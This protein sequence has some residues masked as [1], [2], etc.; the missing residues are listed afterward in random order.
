MNNETMVYLKPNVVLEPLFDRWYAWT[1]LISPAT[2]AMNVKGRH[3]KIMNSYI[4][5]PEAHEKAVKNPKMLG[6]PFMDFKRNRS[7]DV[8]KLMED[9][10]HN[11]KDSLAFADAIQELEKLL[12]AKGK[13][14]SLEPLYQEI[15]E[16]LQGYVELYYDLNNNPTYRI[17]EALLYHAD[18][19]REEAQSIALWLTENDDRPFVLSTPRL[20]DENVLHLNIPF[21]AASIDALFKMRQQAQKL[22]VIKKT[23]GLSADQEALFETFFTEHAPA[24]YKKYEGDKIR[25]RYFGHACVLIETKDVSILVDPLVSYYGF[26]SE[27]AH[28]TDAD[29]PDQ[30]D[31]VL[32]THNH[33]DHIIFETLLP[34]RHRIKNVIVPRTSSG[35]LEDPNLKLMFNHIGFKNVYELT[36]MVDPIYFA[37]C[38][39]T[40]V[41]FLGEHGDLDIRAKVCHHI[42]VGE[43]SLLFM[44]DSCNL[45]P[46]LYDHVQ[47][48]IGDIDVLFLGMECDG[49]PLSWLYGPLL[50][51]PLARDKDDTRR[52]S[53]SNHKRGMRLVQSFNPQEVY[54]Y[55]MGSEPWI[56]FISSIKYTDESNPI[57]QSNR[58]VDDCTEKGLTAERLFGE[59]EI[60]YDKI[61]YKV[62]KEVVEVEM[63]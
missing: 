3:L 17:F 31:Y 50:P 22:G 58:L 14:Y 21:K 6:G 60:L 10:L 61:P 39:I 26:Q 32:I 44:A 42:K 41:P 4:S 25:M 23:M 20:E 46:K 56:Q 63:A 27:V 54:V 16:P 1:H 29:L 37:D 43:F 33:Q 8:K 2:S 53:G 5:A 38:T 55:A 49:A 7:E 28:F 45:Q 59:K 52:F 24:P 30:I 47:K 13:G 34:L 48:Q 40:G 62:R 36:D 19:Y 35:R 51:E 12:K 11:A 15:P 57:V 9:T 18:C